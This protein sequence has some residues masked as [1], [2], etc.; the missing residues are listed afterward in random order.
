MT[1]FSLKGKDKIAALLFSEKLNRLANGLEFFRNY[2]GIHTKLVKFDKDIVL[3]P[4]LKRSSTL[5]PRQWISMVFVDS[6]N[7]I[8]S[9][10]GED[11]C[12][13][14]LQELANLECIGAVFH[15]NDEGLTN[16]VSIIFKPCTQLNPEGVTVVNIGEEITIESMPTLDKQHPLV[17]NF[18]VVH[19]NV[20]YDLEEEKTLATLVSTK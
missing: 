20:F 4:I 7:P 19:K 15:T 3:A 11:R 13:P 12:L 5:A 10:V 16:S 17:G 2:D 8:L 6:L 18:G 1:S 14:V 9:E